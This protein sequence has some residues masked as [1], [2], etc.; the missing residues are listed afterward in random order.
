MPDWL[1]HSL[2]GWIT[3][4]TT[5]Q[6]LG[7]L[8]VGSLIPDITKLYLLFDWVLKGKTESFFLPIHTPVGAVLIACAIALLFHDVTKA[9]IPLGI[10]IATHFILDLLLVNGSGG[11][12][13]A[14]PFS[15]ETWQFNLIRSDDYMMTI[16]AIVAAC[17]VYLVYFYKKR[18]KITQKKR[19]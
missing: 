10:G 1:T 14:F 7:L 18:R 4:K 2:V 19:L 3:G 9:M 8:V 12:P 16:Y 15:W 6:E 13:L 11:M 5:R 17:I